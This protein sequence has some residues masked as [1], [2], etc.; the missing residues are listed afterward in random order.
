MIEYEDIFNG[1]FIMYKTTPLEGIYR[2]TKI[3]NRKCSTCKYEI[4]KFKCSFIGKIKY[5]DNPY[6]SWWKE[7]KF[8]LNNVRDYRSLK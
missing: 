8:K 4:S 5:P 3:S 2:T 7:K 6:C 1:R